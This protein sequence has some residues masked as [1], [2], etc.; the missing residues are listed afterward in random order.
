M[1]QF[2][3]VKAHWGGKSGER[4]RF[5]KGDMRTGEPGDPDI[6]GHLRWGNLKPYRPVEKKD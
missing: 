5:A 2:E 1:A 4:K 3:V 6:R